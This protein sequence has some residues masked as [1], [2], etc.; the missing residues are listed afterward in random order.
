MTTAEK[1]YE[2]YTNMSYDWGYNCQD[3]DEWGPLMD[4]IHNEAIKELA[5]GSG[6]CDPTTVYKFN[7]GS[8]IRVENPGQV[9][10]SGYMQVVA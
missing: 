8:A 10:Y 5:E 3:W 6:S 2:E 9:V 1:F 4:K 7:D